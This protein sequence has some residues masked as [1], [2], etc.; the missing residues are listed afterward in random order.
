MARASFASLALAATTVAF[1]LGSAPCA[2]AQAQPEDLPN[3][4][5]REETFYT[6]VACHTFN[7]VSRQGMSREQWDGTLSWMSERH[8][9]P[10]LEGADRLL[11]LNYLSQA[12]P[13]IGHTPSGGGGG[14]QNP[15]KP[16]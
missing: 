7:L 12:Y 16:Q 11:V 4:P 5:G 15:F 9:M 8:G 14:W 13:S 1:A 10:R 2:F 3:F 6:C